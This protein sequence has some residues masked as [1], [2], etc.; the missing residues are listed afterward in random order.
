M[1]M[2]YCMGAELESN[3]CLIL[4]MSATNRV[5]NCQSTNIINL[6]YIS[7]GNPLSHPSDVVVESKDANASVP[8]IVVCDNH[9]R[10][11]SILNIVL[12]I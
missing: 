6:M 2:K 10:V 7:N 8:G 9:S 1:I 5:T 11:T 3:L 4:S 12:Y